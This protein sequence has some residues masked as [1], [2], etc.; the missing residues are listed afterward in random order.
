MVILLSFTVR[1][2][3]PKNQ[4]TTGVLQPSTLHQLQLFQLTPSLGQISLKIGKTGQT[5]LAQQL[6]AQ[7]IDLGQK[8]RLVR[9][10]VIRTI[11]LYN[12]KTAPLSNIKPAHH[13]VKLMEPYDIVKAEV[14]HN[15]SIPWTAQE[16]YVGLVKICEQPQFRILRE[17][18]TLLVLH[19]EGGGLAEIYLI[20]ADKPAVFS[21]NFK[22]F[23]EA[24]RVGGF[25]YLKYY[26]NRR[27]MI[28]VLKQL[29]ANMTETKLQDGNYLVEIEL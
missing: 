26:T 11:Q 12:M 24:L 10:S 5:K 3:S 1:K 13:D 14:A 25:K 7:V 17:N 9:I 22:Q 19:N 21:H 28:R 2:T 4:R 27:A 6:T 8:T 18:N 20:T 16:M 15:K 23:G 29:S